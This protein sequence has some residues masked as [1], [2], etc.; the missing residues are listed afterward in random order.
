MQVNQSGASLRFTARNDL[1]TK[2]E[3]C[4]PV[5]SV[6]WPF[7]M[8]ACEQTA[9]V[10][11]SVSGVRYKTQIAANAPIHIALATAPMAAGMGR[12][13][14]AKRQALPKS[15][16]A[17]IARLAVARVGTHIRVMLEFA[18]VRSGQPKKRPCNLQNV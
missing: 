3:D 16:A 5:R 4:V 8:S 13:S 1:G 7:Q 17:G 6:T 12:S 10:H 18:M 2:Y 14:L 9:P 15:R 11:N